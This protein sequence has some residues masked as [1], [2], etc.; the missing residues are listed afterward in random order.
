MKKEIQYKTFLIIIAASI[1]YLCGCASVE[2]TL[3]LGDVEVNAPITTPPTHININK[4]PGDVTISPRFAVINKKKMTG[5]TEDRYTQS[6]LLLDSS[7]YKSRNNNVE[8]NFSRYLL[9]TDIDLKLSKG[10]SLFGGFSFS[11]EGN[12]WGGNLG[13]GLHSHSASPAA[14]LDIGISIQKYEYDAVTIVQTKETGFFGDEN[15]YISVFHD[16]GNEVNFN[17]FFS[18]TINSINDSSFLNYFLSAGFFWQSLLGFEPGETD[19]DTF[20]FWNKTTIDER[21]NFTAGF[22]YFNPGLGFNINEQIR[23]LF[24][25]KVLKEVFVTSNSKEWFVVP[26]IQLDFQL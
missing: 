4:E 24:S 21:S 23:I 8:W 12:F 14:R 26:S 16:K 9:G 19:F 5:A 1:L 18:L 22:L 13:I 6:V 20:L 2:Q 10:F 17:P 11:G 15:E 3:Y 25:A 7:E